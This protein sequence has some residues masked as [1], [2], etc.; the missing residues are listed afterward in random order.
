MSRSQW[1]CRNSDCA[2]RG[3]AVLGRVTSDGGLVL[4]PAVRLFA[5]YLDTQR[6]AVICHSCGSAREFRGRFVC[7]Y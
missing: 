4:D 2:T 3:G 1:R 6:A 5:I 7:R